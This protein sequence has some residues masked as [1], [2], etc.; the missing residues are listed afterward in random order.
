MRTEKSPLRIAC[1]ACSRSCWESDFPFK[2]GLRLAARRAVEEPLVTTSLMN[3]L[4]GMRGRISIRTAIGAIKGTA[5]TPKQAGRFAGFP[6]RVPSKNQ[7]KRLNLRTS[8]LFQAF[9][10]SFGRF[11][12]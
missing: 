12:A 11:P 1:S 7:P 6:N 3:F 10:K 4:R 5:K 8:E 2:A 9:E